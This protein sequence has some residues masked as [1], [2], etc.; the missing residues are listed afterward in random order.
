MPYCDEF[1]ELFTGEAFERTLA[2]NPILTIPGLTS[3]ILEEHFGNLD[4]DIISDWLENLFNEYLKNK[5]K[6]K[7]FHLGLGNPNAN[8]LVVGHE[9]AINC[10][11]PN[12]EELNHTAC[13]IDHYY[14]K[15]FVNEAILNY[16][17]WYR[18]VKC[19][20]ILPNCCIQDPEF[21]SSFCT[22]YNRE[23]PFP[24]HYWA[25]LSKAIGAYL[26]RNINNP[27]N[28]RS[29]FQTDLYNKSVFNHVF[30]T[31]LN[32]LPSANSSAKPDSS[33][34]VEK[35]NDLNNIPFFRKFKK[36]IFACHRYLDLHHIETIQNNYGVNVHE[37]NVTHNIQAVYQSNDHKI[38]VCN[39]LAGA[40]GW[41]NIELERLGK[42]LS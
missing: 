16:F 42:L 13:Y 35:I 12:P 36:I 21:P 34:I 31:E 24:G 11:K 2:Q 18:K 3:G 38:I 9:L 40:N 10:N 26:T 6:I 33:T 30:L 15:L 17:L 8:I 28:E 19:K 29:F 32:N 39:N 41:S 1:K 37:E 27:A 14:R 25:N 4:C 20:N 5:E 23:K 22:L 7:P